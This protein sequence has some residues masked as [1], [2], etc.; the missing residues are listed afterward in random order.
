MFRKG[1]VISFYY[2]NVVHVLVWFLVWICQVHYAK[3]VYSNYMYV[4]ILSASRWVWYH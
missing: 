4:L 1:L 3:F 2:L